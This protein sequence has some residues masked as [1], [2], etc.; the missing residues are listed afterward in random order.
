M[1]GGVFSKSSLRLR[2]TLHATGPVFDGGNSCCRWGCVLDGTAPVAAIRCPFMWLQPVNLPRETCNL[3]KVIR[4]PRKSL[5]CVTP[6][7]LI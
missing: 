4:R 1:P 5:L 6:E 2:Q 7:T 3:S